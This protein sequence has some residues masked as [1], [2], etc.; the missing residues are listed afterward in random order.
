MLKLHVHPIFCVLP[1]TIWKHKRLHR[2][3]WTVMLQELITVNKIW[4]K[5]GG[6]HCQK[7]YKIQKNR[8]ALHGDRCTAGRE[9]HAQIHSAL[10]TT[11]SSTSAS[12]EKGGF[13][14]RAMYRNY[15]RLGFSLSVLRCQACWWSQTSQCRCSHGMTCCLPIPWWL[16]CCHPPWLI[17]LVWNEAMSVMKSVAHS[18]LISWVLVGLLLR[19]PCHTL[20]S[21]FLRLLTSPTLSVWIIQSCD[22]QSL[23]AVFPRGLEPLHPSA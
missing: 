1:N 23:V 15:C 11:I 13:F 12:F 5:M 20:F 19:T 22:T 10:C 16:G 14:L 8:C 2:F 4:Q 18:L 21:A 7:G 6:Y 9:A 3:V 17:P